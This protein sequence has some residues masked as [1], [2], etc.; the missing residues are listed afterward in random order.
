[1]GQW[2]G[3]GSPH[4][5]TGLTPSFSR[6][7]SGYPA[8]MCRLHGD[9]ILGSPGSDLQAEGGVWAGRWVVLT[10][11]SPAINHKPLP[12]GRHGLQS[13]L[14][15][16]ARG[17]PSADPPALT[18]RGTQEA[19]G[20]RSTVSFFSQQP[21]CPVQKAAPTWCLTHQLGTQPQACHTNQRVQLCPPSQWDP[22]WSLKLDF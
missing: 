7:L 9:S 13:C 20:A 4:A 21:G 8:W 10:Q 2:S 19:T 14:G 1:M 11:C 6:S 16:P 3:P 5:H 22:G 18:Q 15:P 12:P 17:S